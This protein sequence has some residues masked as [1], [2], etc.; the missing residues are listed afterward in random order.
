MFIDR[1]LNQ[2]SAPLV[3]RMMRF[4]AARHELL[5]ENIANASTPGYQ[6]KDL[7]VP[8]FQK[9]LRDRQAVR[10]RSA[11]G[12]VAFDDITMDVQSPRSGLLFHDRNNRTMEQLQTDLASNALKH[13]MYTEMLR[14]QFDGLENVLKERI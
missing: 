11:P 1:L 6:Q 10:A 4:T 12:S 9:A 8:A 7:S 3:E 2:G 5:A 13:N 14:K